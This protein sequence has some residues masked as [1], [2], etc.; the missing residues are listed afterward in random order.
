MR[1]LRGRSSRVLVA[2]IGDAAVRRARLRT[3]ARRSLGFGDDP[4]QYFVFTELGHFDFFTMT[5]GDKS[6]LHASLRRLPARAPA[7]RRSLPAH[8]LH[9]LRLD[10]ADRAPCCPMSPIV[11]T[12]HEYPADL[13]P[14][15]PD[16]AHQLGELCT[17]AS[18]RRCNECFPESRRR[19]SS[20]ASD[21]SSRTSS[22]STCSWRRARFLLERYVDWGIPRE[23]IR[24]RG[25]RAPPAPAARAR[26][27]RASGRTTGSASSA[28]STLQGRQ[29]PAGGDEDPRRTRASRPT[30][31]CTAPTSSCRPRTSRTSSPRCST[32]PGTTR[33]A[34]AA[35]TTTASCRS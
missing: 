23:Q 5:Y 15:R 32:R 18:P 19:R 16:G 31:G 8:A 30:C 2:R 3:R 7:G 20:C 10:H 14:G 34:S 17:D 1:G 27:S 35:P 12:L 26:R 25:L 13:P 24:V 33:H 4:N 9:R 21:S 6:P 11:Y 22:T 29:G 28:S